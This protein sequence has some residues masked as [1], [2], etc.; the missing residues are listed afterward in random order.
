[1][2]GVRLNQPGESVGLQPDA[3]T[4]S[5]GKNK[6]AG[7]PLMSPRALHHAN[8]SSSGEAGIPCKLRGAVD[9]AV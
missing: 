8:A 1:M 9:D 7:Q 4:S 2:H 6:R 5:G 3:F